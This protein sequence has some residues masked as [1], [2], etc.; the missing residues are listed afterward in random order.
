MVSVVC[1][2]PLAEHRHGVRG[3]L[4]HL[5]HIE[6]NLPHIPQGRSHVGLMLSVRITACCLQTSRPDLNHVNRHEDTNQ[7]ITCVC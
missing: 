2:S 4:R 6:T 7:G 1:F 3:Y 5:G